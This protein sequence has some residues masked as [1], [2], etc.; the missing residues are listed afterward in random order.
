[1]TQEIFVEKHL[2]HMLLTKVE[3]KFNCAV[4]EFNTNSTINTIKLN[5]NIVNIWNYKMQ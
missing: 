2:V 5:Y 4:C 3:V 1:M